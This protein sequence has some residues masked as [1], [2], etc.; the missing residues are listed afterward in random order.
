M[1]AK[2][3]QHFKI[4]VVPACYSKKKKLRIEAGREEEDMKV[5]LFTIPVKQGKEREGG[6]VELNQFLQTVQ[7][8]RCVSQIVQ[9]EKGWWWTVFVGYEEKGAGRQT[10]EDLYQ[11]LTPEQKEIYE[12]L[13]RWRNTEAQKIGKKPYEILHNKHLA[14]LAM[15]T[16]KTEEDIAK[17]AGTSMEKVNPY[18][19]YILSMLT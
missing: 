16:P 8:M 10:R 2:I 9:L 5:K 17:I 14:R 4:Y 7:V 15:Q 3:K 19:R 12:R 6:E 18:G 13:R 11:K 1:A